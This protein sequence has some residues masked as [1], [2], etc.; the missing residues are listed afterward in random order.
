MMVKVSVI[1]PVYNVENYLEE[2]LDSIINQTLKDIEIICINDGSTDG[3]LEILNDYAGSDSR[4]KLINQENEG[5]GAARNHG[6]KLSQ[7]EYIYFMDS[8]DILELFALE[9][10]YNMS[11]SMD[12]DILIFK[13]INFND[14]SHEKYTSK[15]YEMPFLNKYAGKIF[16]YNT[17]GE[18]AM[19]IAVSPPG[20]LFKRSLIFSMKFPEGVIFEDNY[21]FAEAMLKAKKV[22]FLDKYLYNRRIRNNSITNNKTIKL[23]DTIVI[24][25]KLFDL[26]KEFGV[27]NKFK[28]SLIE[29]KIKSEYNRF[30]Q[31]DEFYKEEFFK[32]IQED[33]RS[34][35]NEFKNDYIF[36]KKIHPT[37]RYIFNKALESQCYDDFELGVEIF[38]QKR[39]NKNLRKKKNKLEK[40]LKKLKKLNK[41]LINSNS[42]RL[43]KPFRKIFGVFRK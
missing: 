25:N 35:E 5:Q 27:Y 37:Y 36:L 26:F 2:C 16:N 13:L 17:L 30:S 29:K 21:F 41:E 9:E 20:K 24:S 11:K 15:Y 7:G 10:L 18:K 4:L 28:K 6:I 12:L 23:A 3:S 42:W 32:M 14:G 40:K 19:N 43:T 31:V 1:I 34:F 8:D 33:F 22:S 38:I 39:K